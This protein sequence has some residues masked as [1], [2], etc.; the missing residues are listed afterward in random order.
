ML[1]DSFGRNISLHKTDFRTLKSVGRFSNANNRVGGCKLSFL[2]DLRDLQPFSLLSCAQRHARTNFVHSALYS[3]N[4]GMLRY[5]IFDMGGDTI[6]LGRPFASPCTHGSEVTH[7]LG[8]GALEA[9]HLVSRLT[10][11]ESLRRRGRLRESE[12]S[13]IVEASKL[14]EE[15][16]EEEHKNVL[17]L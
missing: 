16:Q 14:R 7:K 9:L 13:A 5:K 3:I 17:Q 11:Y 12:V 15:Q 1:V 10:Y 6:N 4:Y 8:S 2:Q